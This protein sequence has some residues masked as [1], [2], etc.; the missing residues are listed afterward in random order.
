MGNR[1]VMGWILVA[2]ALLA[3][4]D[5][6]THAG[7]EGPAAQTAQPPPD[8]QPGPDSQPQ[9]GVP[10]GTLTKAVFDKSTLY[11][12][13]VRDYWV[14]IPQQLDRIE[15]RAGDGLPGRSPVRRPPSSS[16][17]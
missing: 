4:T 16:T 10:K 17:I 9:D 7:P 12:G 6:A 13:T 5:P 8:P 11:P 14:Y 15:A 3:W 1:R 2:V